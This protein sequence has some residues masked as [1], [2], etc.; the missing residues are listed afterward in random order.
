MEKNKI[1]KTKNQFKLPTIHKIHLRPLQIACIVV[2]VLF[3]I[4]FIRV[5]LW[6]KSYLANMVGKERSTTEVIG[7]EENTQIDETEPETSE[8]AEYTVAPDKPRYFSA[9][10][11]GIPRTRIV[12]IGI[13]NNGELAT[14]YNIYDVGWYDGSTLPGGNGVSIMD[15]H[16]GYATKAI[17]ERLPNIKIGDQIKIEMGDGRLFTYK[18]VD[19]V[20]KNLGEDANN[21]MTTAFTSPEEGKGSLTLITCTGDY[22][23]KSRTYSQRFFVRA[24]LE[25]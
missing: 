15:G 6:E 12:E 25:Q 13:K 2:A 16:G 18:V 7:L 24:V 22:W 17:F 5:A 11:I 3:A 9:D 14:P 8:I 10:S 21:Y 4:F 19:T 20:T 23:I 1:I